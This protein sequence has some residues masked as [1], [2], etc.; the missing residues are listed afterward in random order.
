MPSAR[1]PSRVLAPVGFF[2]FA[3]CATTPRVGEFSDRELM[4]AACPAG[5]AKKVA[6]SVWTKIESKE[7]S[8]QFPATVS[9]DYPKKLAVEVT[10]LIGAPQA[11]LTIE[12]GKTELKFTD[13]N[14]K[15]YGRP[16][17]SRD[18]LGGLPVELAPRLFAGGVP[19][20]VDDSNSDI[21]VKQTEDGALEAT[22][23]D[24]R[25]RVSTRYVYRFTRYAG[26]PWVREAQVE[27]SAR[28]GG[29]GAKSNRITIS[30]EEPVDPDG[31]PKRWAASSPRGEIRVRW[32]D[33]AVLS[34]EDR[35]R[36]ESLVK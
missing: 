36:S 17:R 22:A 12:A 2:L 5:L 24:L 4:D 9:V 32:K 31:A 8:G 20:P 33:R 29:S 11:W 28:S 18:M 7:M 1:L 23:L 19:C 16:P 6:G 21:R 35:Q 26:R 15:E 3:A 30:R 27:K 10:N 25:S 34:T 14:E 13:E